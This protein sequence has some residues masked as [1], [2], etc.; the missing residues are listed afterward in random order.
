MPA[1]SQA[2]VLLFRVFKRRKQAR[3]GC[4]QTLAQQNTA[5][6]A[7]LVSL[8]KKLKGL[9]S[10]MVELAQ[11]KDSFRRKVSTAASHSLQIKCFLFK[12]LAIPGRIS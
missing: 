1:G 3:M 4:S 9:N 6:K 7:A 5:M 2:Q 11:E 12:H 8:Q 10:Q